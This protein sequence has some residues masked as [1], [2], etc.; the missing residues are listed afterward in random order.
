M[1]RTFYRRRPFGSTRPWAKPPTGSRT[2][3]IHEERLDS[4][5]HCDRAPIL[6]FLVLPN[7]VDI[8]ASGAYVCGLLA[9]VIGRRY[10]V[11]IDFGLKLRCRS[12]IECSYRT[13]TP[14][15]CGVASSDF[16]HLKNNLSGPALMMKIRRYRSSD[17][18]AIWELHNVA[19]LQIGAHAGNGPWDGDLHRIEA[20]YISPGGDFFGDLQWSNRRHGSPS[21]TLGRL[22][23]HTARES[24][25]GCPTEGTR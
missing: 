4:D 17:H 12:T 3:R 16:C 8:A 7:D 5:P 18:D 2:F 9:S 14:S 6:C 23:Q 10:R 1:F 19:L 15:G 21:A 11:D 13:R 20:E 22:S 24:A 25:S